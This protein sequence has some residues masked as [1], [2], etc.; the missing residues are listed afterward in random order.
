MNRQAKKRRSL[1]SVR[2]LLFPQLQMLSHAE[3]LWRDR[4]TQLGMKRA[5]IARC[6]HRKRW[7]QSECERLG[8]FQENK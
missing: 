4:A 6:A 2:S 7:T 3:A 8:I 5:Y 1:V